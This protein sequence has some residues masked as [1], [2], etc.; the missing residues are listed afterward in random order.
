MPIQRTS[1]GGKPGYRYGDSGK[2]YTYKAGS[3]AS[4]E[5]AK[6]KAIQQGLAIAQR[7]GRKP[8]L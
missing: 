8:E 5:R 4:R 1:S 3:A 6:K 2:V 7:Q